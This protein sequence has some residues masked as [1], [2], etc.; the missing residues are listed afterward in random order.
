MAV[1][2]E[3]DA[4]EVFCKKH[5]KDKPL[6]QCIQEMHDHLEEDPDDEFDAII[7]DIEY[8]E[9]LGILEDYDDLENDE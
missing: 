4:I 7:E 1:Y 5:A 6:H 8:M 3:L 9:E 2:W